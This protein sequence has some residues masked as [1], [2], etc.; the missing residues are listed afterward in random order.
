VIRFRLVDCRRFKSLKWF[1]SHLRLWHIECVRARVWIGN[2]KPK[3]ISPL[4]TSNGPSR[5]SRAIQVSDSIPTPQRM[6]RIT[7][8][9][10]Q[11]MQFIDKRR[12]HRGLV[13]VTQERGTRTRWTRTRHARSHPGGTARED[14]PG[15]GVEAMTMA[16]ANKEEARRRG[17]RKRE[18]MELE[19]GARCRPRRTKKKNL[20]T[21]ALLAKDPKEQSRQP[22]L[23]NHRVAAVRSLVRSSYGRY[24]TR[25]STAFVA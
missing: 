1:V 9:N 3:R 10:P 2:G 12:I 24:C 11:H 13:V 14:G 4:P 15:A 21:S 19:K 23:S 6:A 16:A 17:G 20:A 25:K 8:L 7:T 18:T 22:L 5:S